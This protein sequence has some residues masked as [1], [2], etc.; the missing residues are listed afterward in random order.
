MLQLFYL[1]QVISFYMAH[2]VDLDI[3]GRIAIAVSSEACQHMYSGV[4]RD[5]VR[6]RG[7]GGVGTW[8]Q[9]LVYLH[10]ISTQYIYTMYLLYLHHPSQ[11]R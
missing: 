5:G 7:G 4:T 10:N 6:C 1:I 11:M 2:L 8:D 9:S 3:C